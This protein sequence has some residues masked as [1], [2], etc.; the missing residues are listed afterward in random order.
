MSKPLILNQAKAKPRG[1]STQLLAGSLFSSSAGRFSVAYFAGSSSCVS[2][3]SSVRGAERL[4]QPLS[5]G[6]NGGCDLE[7]IVR[8]AVSIV[9][10]L[11]SLAI[12]VLYQHH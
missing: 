3:C 12:A 1:G 11:L 10:L 4:S 7:T 8:Y 6:S 2:E 5:D 9:P